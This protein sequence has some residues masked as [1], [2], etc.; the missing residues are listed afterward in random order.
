MGEIMD[1]KKEKVEEKRNLVS[2]QTVF[3]ETNVPSVI[4]YLSL[5]VEGTEYLVMKYFPWDEYCF[6]FMTIER[7]NDDLKT[8]LQLHGYKLLRIITNWGETFW[9]HEKLVL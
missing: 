2:I 4:D 5:D 7:P 9:I 1:N 6:E 8:M 3:N